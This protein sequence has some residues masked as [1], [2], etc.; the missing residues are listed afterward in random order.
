MNE[1]SPVWSGNTAETILST[2][3]ESCESRVFTTRNTSRFLS[4]IVEINNNPPI[5]PKKF[6][7]AFEINLSPQKD[8]DKPTENPP[9]QEGDTLYELTSLRLGVEAAE[10]C[11][12]NKSAGRHKQALRLGYECRREGLPEEYAV[13]AATFFDGLVRETNSDGGHEPLKFAEIEDAV[14]NAYKDDAIVNGPETEP[15]SLASLLDKELPPPS[16]II[17]DFLPEGVTILAGDPKAGKSYLTMNIN[18]AVATGKKALSHYSCQQGSVL[19]LDLEGNPR[20]FSSRLKTMLEGRAAPQS[21]YAKYEGWARGTSAATQIEKWLLRRPDTRLVIIDTL[22]MVRDTNGGKKTIYSYDY[23]AIAPFRDLAAQYGIGVV[24]VHHTNKSRDEQAMYR[25]SGTN[26]LP[27]AADTLMVLERRPNQRYAFL[28]ISGRCIE[29]QEIGLEFT[30]TGN[31][32]WR[33]AQE[34]RLSSARKEIL[35]LLKD[36]GPLGPTQIKIEL[37]KN[38]STDSDAPEKDGRVRPGKEGWKWKQDTIRDRELMLLSFLA[39]FPIGGDKVIMSIKK[40][41]TTQLCY[42]HPQVIVG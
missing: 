29:Q 5:H 27:G 38:Y 16:W 8:K 11:L 32:V 15:I 20:L 18:L 34:L 21:S 17:D 33:D 26:A 41:Y 35:E 39:G 23:E 9:T 31:W 7:T 13:Q 4:R 19:H 28:S 25:I 10:Y 30:G 6:V 14:L 36:A 37:N 12:K 24:I 42:H 22:Q 2:F 40:S 3:R 1:Y